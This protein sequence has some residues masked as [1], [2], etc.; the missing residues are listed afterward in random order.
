[1]MRHSLF[2]LAALGA[3]CSDRSAST[4]PLTDESSPTLGA[5][6]G[7]ARLLAAPADLAQRGPSPVG[8]RTITIDGLTVELVETLAPR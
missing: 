6:C 7:G 4:R 1:M 3:G 8:A 5:A 2:I